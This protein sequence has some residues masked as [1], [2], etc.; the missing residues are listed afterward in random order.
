VALSGWVFVLFDYDIV[1]VFVI[2]G[3]V[4]HCPLWLQFLGYECVDW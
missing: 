1:C 2:K 3:N 4:D